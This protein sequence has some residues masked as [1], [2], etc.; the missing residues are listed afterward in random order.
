MT[1]K[2]CENYKKTKIYIPIKIIKTG[3]K[4]IFLNC[5][6]SSSY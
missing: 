3:F 2:N 1:I 5:F 4:Q 6:E